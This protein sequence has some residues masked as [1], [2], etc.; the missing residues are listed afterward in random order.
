MEKYKHKHTGQIVT[1]GTDGLFHSKEGGY[2]LQRWI[3]ENSNDWEEIK[4][5]KKVSELNVKEEPNYLITAFRLIS[6]GEI[7]KI[8]SDGKYGYWFTLKD[9]LSSPPC[10]ESGDFEIYSV[11]NSKG[12]FTLG[13]KVISCKDKFTISK[14]EICGDGIIVHF[15]E[16]NEYDGLELISKIK[17]PIYTTTDGVDIW[18]GYSV[19]LYLLNKDLVPC[20]RNTV[21]IFNFNKQ[22][23]EV[24][25]R[26]LTFT[27]EENRDK[28]IK[29]YTRKPIFTSVDGVEIYDENHDV[30]SVIS[31]ERNHFTKSKAYETFCKNNSYKH[32][33]TKEARQ[34][35]I[36]KN[37]PKYSLAD[38][39]NCYPKPDGFENRIKDIPLAA[40]LF[41]N[42]KKLGK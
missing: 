16:I 22:D 39:E 35:Y 6:D 24:A 33:S 12:E 1:K 34:E 30:Y 25:D 26:Y 8:G 4:E 38:I 20:I 10:V 27:S 2:T 9:M 29:E 11:K 21:N 41:S 3:F 7:V 18:E 32:F 23:K 13:E 42:L 15:K 36:D 28:Y 17:Q 31:I 19:T 40:T 5:V 37:K 14:F